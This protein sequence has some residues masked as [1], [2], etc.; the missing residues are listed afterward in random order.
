[1]SYFVLDATDGKVCGGGD[2]MDR[3][4]RQSNFETCLVRT[5]SVAPLLVSVMDVALGIVDTRVRSALSR[6]K[7]VRVVLLSHETFV[8]TDGSDKQ[9]FC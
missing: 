3:R 2:W 9:G 6:M 7:L 1:M 8:S 4:V 5:A